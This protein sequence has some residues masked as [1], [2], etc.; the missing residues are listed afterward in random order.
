MKVYIASNGCAV[1]KH[2]T[3]RIAKF[4]KSNGWERSSCVQNADI[5]VMTCCGVTH[6]EENEAIE[7]IK[8]IEKERKQS[9]LFIIGGCLPAFAEERILRVAPAAKLLAYQQLSTLDEIIGA[10]ISFDE[11]YYNTHPTLDN[12]IIDWKPNNEERV[13]LKID[14]ICGTH[15]CKEQYDLCTLRKYIWQDKDVYQIKVS[16][17][18]PGNCS[19]CATKLAI[20]N[21][22][23]VSKELVIKQ[24]KE[25][26]EA[27]YGNFMM[28]GDEVGCYGS[29]FGENIIMLLNEI[30]S[31][32]PNISIA[33]R[34]IHPDVFVRH[35]NELKPYFATGFINYFCC[36]IQSASPSI[37]KAMNRNPNIEPFIQCLEDMNQQGYKVNKHT[38]ILVGFPN[39]TDADV[40]DTIDCLIR[41]DFDHININKFSPRKGTKAYEMDDNIPE[42]IKIKRC[43]IFG[44]LMMMN[45]K[46]KLYNAINQS[47]SKIL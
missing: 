33:I 43:A 9:S 1:L 6:N 8:S 47:V 10:T 14:G 2:E 25:G 21:F 15:N 22:R 12:E 18:C 16:Y 39:E 45:K 4:F 41:C 40:L 3:E 23:S 5:V 20:G 35:Y 30:Y 44:K 24:F 19:Y 36:A 13:L 11:I 26:V 34:Y 31:F 32:A 7:I 28:V 29:D 42:S 27:G 38:Q 17:G 46:E 37:L